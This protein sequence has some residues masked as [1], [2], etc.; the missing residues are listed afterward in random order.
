MGFQMATIN[1]GTLKFTG[2]PAAT[3]KT[4]PIIDSSEGVGEGGGG[5]TRWNLVANPFPSY[6]HG[7]T[8]ADSSNNFLTSNS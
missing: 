8:N 6:I 1:G 4:W 7:N 2:A 3:N 5:G